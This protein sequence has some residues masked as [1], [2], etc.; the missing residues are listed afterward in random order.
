M[1]TSISFL[2][3][4]WKPTHSASEFPSLGELLPRP[5]LQ[6]RIQLEHVQETCHEKLCSQQWHLAH[7]STAQK[8]LGNV[9]QSCACQNPPTLTLLEYVRL[10]EGELIS[11]RQLGAR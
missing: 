3:K 1:G 5:H 4:L 9:Y 2:R 8:L 11:V 6:K 10:V 7:F